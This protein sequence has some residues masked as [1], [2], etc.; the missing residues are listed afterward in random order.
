MTSLYGR[1]M[2]HGWAE[3]AGTRP[4]GSGS[5]GVTVGKGNQ[6]L[7]T[8]HF[9]QV[10]SCKMKQGTSSIRDGVISQA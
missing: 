3:A 1:V 6:L 10:H 7:P 2:Y 8:P 9:K 5:A 4:A